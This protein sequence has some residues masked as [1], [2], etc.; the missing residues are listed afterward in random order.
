M[1][2]FIEFSD[3]FKQ[4]I[5]VTWQCVELTFSCSVKRK[6]SLIA[7]ITPF[8]RS[9]YKPPAISMARSNKN[10]ELELNYRSWRFSTSDQCQQQAAKFRS[11]HRIFANQ[12]VTKLAPI[13][14]QDILKFVKPKLAKTCYYCYLLVMRQWVIYQLFIT[15]QF[16]Y[17]PVVWRHNYLTIWFNLSQNIDK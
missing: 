3:H 10:D 13:Y 11:S 9:D 2:S 17:I 1:V 8:Y 14:V 5:F 4:S 7:R 15:E 12:Y 6:S 16:N